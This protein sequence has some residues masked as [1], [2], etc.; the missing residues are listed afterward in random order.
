MKKF[1]H[2]QYLEIY[3]KVQRLCVEVV[4]VQDNGV[5]LTLRRIPPAKGLWHLP[6]GIVFYDE[7]I[8]DAVYRVA[9]AE[10]GVTVEII[11]FLGYADYD[12]NKNAIGHSVSLFFL[13]K[14]IEG[15]IKTDFQAKEAKFFKK[16]PEDMIKE[17]KKFIEENLIDRE[18]RV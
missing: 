18:E 8:L 10:L 4:I 11:K 15:V 6:G 16:L 9:K 17:D 12:I 5:L 7:S 1:P 3:S 2:D 14:I 13:T